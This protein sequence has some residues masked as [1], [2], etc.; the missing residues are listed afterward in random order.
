[1]VQALV[2]IYAAIGIAGRFLGDV[3]RALIDPRISF[4]KKG[5]DR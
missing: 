3:L 2:L 4:V 1:M 5:D